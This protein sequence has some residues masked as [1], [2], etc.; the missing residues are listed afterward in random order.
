MKTKTSIIGIVVS[1]YIGIVGSIAY[2]LN[3]S[4]DPIVEKAMTPLIDVAK[5]NH[6]DKLEFVEIADK[7]IPKDKN[8][9]CPQ[10]EDEFVEYGLFPVKVFSYIAWRESGCNP[11]A[12]NAKFDSNGNVIWTLNKDGSIDRGLL[13]I[14]SSWKTV[15]KNVC[16]TDLNG[17]LILDCNLKV[18]KYIMDNS[19]GKLLNW[20]IPNN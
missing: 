19:K 16:G 14:N 1:L 6:G 13:Q 7:R 5:V 3:E 11:Q 20:R 17:L 9:R 15:T 18:A 4:N 10:F 8:K 2:A 12:I